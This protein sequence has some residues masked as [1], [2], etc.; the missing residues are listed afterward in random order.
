MPVKPKKKL[1][2]TP[3]IKD[4]QLQIL[5]DGLYPEGDNDGFGWFFFYEEVIEDHKLSLYNAI[6]KDFLADWISSNPCTRPWAWY[7]Y[8][9][10]RWSDPWVDCFY[11][12][13]FAEPREHISGGKRC[14]YNY[15]PSFYKATFRYWHFAENDPPL[16]ESEAAYLKRLNLLTDAEE[17]HLAKHPELLEPESIIDAIPEIKSEMVL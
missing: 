11:H 8:D 7:E 17:K 6:K 2:K 10:P 16:F 15:V 14:E 3:E 12:G 4:W 9:A 5:K 13:T 1:K